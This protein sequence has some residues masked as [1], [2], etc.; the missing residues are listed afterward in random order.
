MPRHGPYRIELSN[1]ERTVL[2]SLARSYTL[3]VLAGDEGSDGADGRGWA[4]QRSDRRAAALWARCRIAVAQAVP[5]SASGRPRGPVRA[6]Q[7]ADLDTLEQRLL[8]FGRRYEQIATPFEWK[9]TRENLN[10]LAHQTDQP[11]SRPG[12][13]TT[14]T[15]TNFQARALR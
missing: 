5:R 14:N 1:G 7:T 2:E 8:A 15:S 9:F 4:A 13:L 10:R 11:T 3:P 12:S 6:R